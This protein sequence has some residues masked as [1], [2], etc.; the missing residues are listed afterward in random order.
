MEGACPACKTP[1]TTGVAP[2]AVGDA[3]EMQP[4]GDKTTDGFLRVA[5]VAQSLGFHYEVQ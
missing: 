3:G 4:G 1:P 2:D 5:S